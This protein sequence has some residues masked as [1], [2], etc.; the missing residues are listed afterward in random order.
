MVPASVVKWFFE[1]RNALITNHCIPGGNNKPIFCLLD[2]T[3]DEF[4]KSHADSNVSY[5]NKSIIEEM[6]III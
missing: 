5:N 2:E 4:I 3:F 1:F 6:R